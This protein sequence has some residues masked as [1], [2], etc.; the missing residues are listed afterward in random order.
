MKAPSTEDFRLEAV[1]RF[2]ELNL[3]RLTELQDIVDLAAELCQKPVA[4][5]TL[6]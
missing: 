5:L 4:L 3:D 2:L 1:E 6:L